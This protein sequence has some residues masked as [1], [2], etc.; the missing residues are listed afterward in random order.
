M[1]RCVRISARVE[2]ATLHT[3]INVSLHTL[4]TCT[5]THTHT[6]AGD[7]SGVVER[8]AVWDYVFQ[9]TPF[10]DYSLRPYCA[11]T[12]VNESVLAAFALADSAAGKVPPGGLC[13]LSLTELY[14]SVKAITGNRYAALYHLY[15]LDC[16]TVYS[17]HICQQ[18]AET[19]SSVGTSCVWVED[20]STV[21]RALAVLS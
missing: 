4:C 7:G 18:R 16:K 12:G 11:I 9:R 8:A 17:V 5:R 2:E 10:I 3:C 20:V 21:T 14:L 15:A 6:G 13:G 1:K 19:L